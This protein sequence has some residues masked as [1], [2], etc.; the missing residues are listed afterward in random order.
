MMRQKLRSVL[1]ISI[2]VLSLSISALAQDD[3]DLSLCESTMT[4][5]SAPSLG[6]RATMVLNSLQ[7]GNTT[8]AETYISP[9]TYIQHNLSIPDGRDGLIG[10]IPAAAE[11][12]S[13]VNIH[14]V[15]VQGDLVALHTSYNLPAFGGELVAFDVFRF[16]DGLI[17]EHWDN[18]V[19]L[20]EPNPSGHTQTDGPIGVT[21]L[22]QTQVNCETVVEFVTRSL[23]NHDPNLDITQYINPASYTQHNSS[24]GDG[25]GSFGSFMQ[26]L[27]ENNQAMIYSNIGLVVAQGNFVLVG[28]EGTFG[29]AD[30]PTPT[31]YYDL[32]RLEDGLIVEHWDVI[33]T[34]PPE[35]EWANDNGKF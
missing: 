7:T 22:N 4:T 23:I 30:N 24:I 13:S 27:A 5:E 14:R 19:P 21:D 1:I 6:V 18:L 28:S 3:V 35:G 25:L 31:A 12:G 2:L 20:A 26:S 15:L 33:T 29:D 34:I 9:D 11:G 8:A 32:F 17:V 16:E 10:L